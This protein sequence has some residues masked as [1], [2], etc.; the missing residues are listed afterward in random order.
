MKRRGT[1]QARFSY[2]RLVQKM[3]EEINTLAYFAV[4]IIGKDNEIFITLISGGKAPG[5][6]L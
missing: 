6:T 3:A 4:R 1:E 5:H 2:V